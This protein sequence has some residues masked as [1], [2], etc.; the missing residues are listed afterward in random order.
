[1][2]SQSQEPSSTA[3]TINAA[4]VQPS[5]A[6]GHPFNRIEFWWSN[7]PPRSRA[8]LLLASGYD[9]GQVMKVADY[10]W[11]HLT[12]KTQNDVIRELGS[13]AMLAGFVREATDEFARLY[14]AEQGGES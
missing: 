4:S 1:M 9:I 11:S 7:M 14:Q 3:A 8:G 10:A 6:Y 13:Q 12:R 5:P 2:L